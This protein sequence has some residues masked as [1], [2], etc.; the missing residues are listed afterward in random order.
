MPLYIPGS[1]DFKYWNSN[2]LNTRPNAAFGATVV[3]A[4]NSYGS[5]VQLLSGANV[6]QDCY[7]ILINA[8]SNAVA[9]TVRDTL[10]TIG[11]D[12]S[13]GTSYTDWLT[14]LLVSGAAP[15]SIGAGGVWYYFPMLIKAGTSL[16]AKASVN[17][18]TVGTLR[19][20]IT[21]FGSPRRPESVRWAT[22]FRAFGVNTGSSSGTGF[23]LGTTNE[24]AWSQV[25]TTSDSLWW[26]QVGLG[27][28]D[29]SMVAAVLHL[30]VSAGDASNKKILIE[31]TPI[32]TD[33]SER[34]SN[35]PLT[36]GCVANVAS[37]DN[38]YVRGQ[39]SGTADILTAAVYGCG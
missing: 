25:G 23:T 32:V 30:D 31:N 5:Y 19:C 8:N 2:V 12:E 21:V 7:G 14:H 1:Q 9:N 27:S 33:T 37:G 35:L 26:W 18:A 24:G 6:T 28:A 10:L 17:N 38:L 20:N 22:K 29:S 39:T 13:G 15:Y 16:A 4:Q 11:K 3:P 36:V 34:I